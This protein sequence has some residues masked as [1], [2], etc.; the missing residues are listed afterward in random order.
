MPGS[1]SAASHPVPLPGLDRNGIG[2]RRGATMTRHVRP[3]RRVPGAEVPEPLPLPF[4]PRARIDPTP[5]VRTACPG[6]AS[7]GSRRENARF[8]ILSDLLVDRNPEFRLPDPLPEFD[9]LL[10][11]G[12]VAIGLDVALNWLA[13]ALDGRQGNRPVLMVAGSAELWSETPMVEAVARGREL[14]RDLGIHLLADDAV[15]IGPEAGGGTVVV[16]ATLWTDWCLEGSFEGRLARV[17]ARHSW[18]DCRRVLLRRGRPWSPLDALGAHA[19]S[20]G[21]IEDALTSIVCQSLNVARG[22]RDAR[23][24]CSPRGPRRRAHPLRAFTPFAARRLDG[25]ARG[26]LAGS[27][28]CLGPGGCH[29]RLGGADAL[30][31]RPGRRPGGLPHWPDQG[32]RQPLAAL[33]CGRCLRLSLGGRGLRWERRPTAQGRPHQAPRTG[34]RASGAGKGWA[35]TAPF[36]GFPP[37]AAAA[38][39]FPSRQRQQ[40]LDRIIYHRY[41]IGILKSRGQ[42]DSRANRFGGCEAEPVRRAATAYSPIGSFR[43]PAGAPAE[44]FESV[45]DSLTALERAGL[46][47]VDMASEPG[48]VVSCSVLRRAIRTPRRGVPPRVEAGVVAAWRTYPP[49]RLDRAEATALARLLATTSILGETR[50]SAARD[51]DAAAATALAIRHVRTCGAASVASDLVMGNLLLMAERGDAT[52]PAVIAYAL[53]ALARRS[54]DERR[55]MRL[56]A[57]WARPRMRKSRRR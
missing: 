11:A 56:A 21:Y 4:R 39:T 48:R 3:P 38:T 5:E 9:V 25:M 55:L 33:G 18:A 42:F 13:R 22:P 45:T 41:N 1:T 43:L 2:G 12:G 17:A 37:R 15:R 27:L 34:R 28:A 23:A 52:A 57:R 53:R 20:R 46:L 19:R 49:G 35:G 29:A 6:P 40:W 50:W 47:E 51:G 30:G 10:V 54:A 7:V 32:G 14:A 24:R 31:P 8:W 16:G 36:A 26:R 44:F